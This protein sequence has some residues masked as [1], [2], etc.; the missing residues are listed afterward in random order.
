VERGIIKEAE[1]VLALGDENPTGQD[2]TS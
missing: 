2:L 1:P